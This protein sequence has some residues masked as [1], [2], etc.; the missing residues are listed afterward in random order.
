MKTKHQ[1]NTEFRLLF[2]CYCQNFHL[3]RHSGNLILKPN[4]F[5]YDQ[6]N[7]LSFAFIPRER[8]EWAQCYSRDGKASSYSNSMIQFKVKVHKI[9]TQARDVWECS[10]VDPFL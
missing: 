5:I 10:F 3:Y 6:T 2:D 8:S 9:L 1:R 4:Y 7:S